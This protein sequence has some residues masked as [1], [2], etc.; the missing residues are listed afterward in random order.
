MTSTVFVTGANDEQ[1][2]RSGKVLP[3]NA[4]GGGG[5]GGEKIVKHKIKDDREGK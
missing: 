4:G 3:R 5:G 1:A 2:E